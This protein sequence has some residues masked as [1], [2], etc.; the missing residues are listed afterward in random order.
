M[1]MGI[2][3][4]AVLISI[5]TVSL[6]LSSGFISYFALEEYGMN[7]DRVVLPENMNNY[8]SSSQDFSLGTFNQSIL[9]SQSSSFQILSG[10][11]KYVKDL[12]IILQSSGF[13]ST[14]YFV[15]A[16]IDKGSSN[17]IT[18]SYI[19][20]N[21]VHGDYRI[22][23]R[24][25]GSSDENEII[26]KSDGFHIPNYFNA[27]G[28]ITGDAD[29][30]PY[31]NANQID[32]VNFITN[33]N[34]GSKNIN[35]TVTFSF[36][37]NTFTSNKLHIAETSVINFKT[38]YGGVSSNTEGFNFISFTTNN[39]IVNPNA[40]LNTDPILQLASLIVTMIK[41]VTWGLPEE[42]VP[43]LLQWFMIRTQE[44]ILIIAIALAL[45]GS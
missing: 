17:E 29:F 40:L 42:I 35:P 1:I 11:W 18:N 24:Y 43:A 41:L 30:I 20:N 39:K 13:L 5:I 19:I 26:V 31:P 36:N 12:G 15:I 6:A 16:N 8:F 38:Y 7:L 27:F 2:Y 14:N 37:G 34:D 32:K 28:I 22:V 33:Y 9:D 25:T 44:A 23:L 10:T 45:R 4:N 21:S 3:T